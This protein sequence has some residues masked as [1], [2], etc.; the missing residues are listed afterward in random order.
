MSRPVPLIT[1]LSDYGTC[2][3]FVGVC[4]AV[5]AR[6]C[7]RG[8]IIDLGHGVA[9]HD[10]RAGAL[11]L[12]AALRYC[13]AGVHLAIVD[14]GVGGARRAVALRVAATGR[15]LVGPDNGLLAVA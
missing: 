6:R 9:R 1:F 2:D 3:E 7:P 4:H 8:R 15:I 5:I 10:V 14:P 13:P 12:D 11:A